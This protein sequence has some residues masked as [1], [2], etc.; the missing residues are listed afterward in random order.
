MLGA[1]LGCAFGL[2]WFCAHWFN[3]DLFSP[4]KLYLL[5]LFV[6]FF[7]I[8]LSPYRLE[9]CCIYVGLLLV[10]LALVKYESQSARRFSNL[11][12]RGKRAPRRPPSGAR[13]IV[14]IWMLT[15]IPLMS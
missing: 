15:T 12:G 7:D 14:L 8:F 6:C 1:M 10:P 11:G 13:P 2:V 5:T 4:I 3:S 9:I